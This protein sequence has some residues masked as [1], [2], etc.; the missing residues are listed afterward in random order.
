MGEQQDQPAE[1]EA[2]DRTVWATRGDAGAGEQ[3]A[4]ADEDDGIQVGDD[5]SPRPDEP[6]DDRASRRERAIDRGFGRG[7]TRRQ[8]RRL[9]VVACLVASALV[10]Q[11][12]SS[13]DAGLRGVVPWLESGDGRSPGQT[14]SAFFHAQAAGDCERLLDLLT[15]ESWSDGGRLTRRQ[16]LDRCADAVDGYRPTVGEVRIQRVDGDGSPASDGDR[17]TVSI[18]SSDLVDVVDGGT[19]EPPVGLVHEDGEW[20]VRTDPAVLHL[21]RSVEETFAA[22]VQ[23]YN[24]GDCATITD[25]LAEDTWS[26]GGEL[27]RDQF[28]ELCGRAADRRRE[29]ALPALDLTAGPSIEDGRHATATIGWTASAAPAILRDEGEEVTLIR[30]AFTWRIEGAEDLAGV[31]PWAPFASVAHAELQAELVDDLSR[32]GEGCFRYFDTAV[33]PDDGPW[34]IR[35]EFG[36]GCYVLVTVY[37]LG[38]ADDARDFAD[39]HATEI[40]Q[41]P[42]L[43]A[44]EIL[45]TGTGVTREEA[46]ESAASY[47]PNQTAPVPG[48]ADAFGLRTR[49]SVDG[50]LSGEVV[51]AVDD[52]VVHVEDR[53]GDDLTFAASV[54]QRQQEALS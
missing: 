4:S 12:A 54:L 28:L 47:R 41:D 23:A 8:R 38:S 15:E 7:L 10:W 20:R 37:Q 52:V 25:L 14:V 1:D 42:P 18:A 33:T 24:S 32:D 22:Y 48:R 16:F 50:C 46:E 17:A 36:V 31:T 29:Q 6:P 39:A 44:E 19:D 9:E 27:D 13:D 3:V 30:D 43:T 34:G 49:C 11:A 26:Q 51:V 35:R 21:G 2:D 5:G 45:D 53:V 40:L